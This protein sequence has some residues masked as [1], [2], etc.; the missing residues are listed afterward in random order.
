MDWPTLCKCDCIYAV[1]RGEL[2]RHG[3]R[4]SGASPA[5]R[6]GPHRGPRVECA[7]TWLA[8]GA[9]LCALAS[10]KL[11]RGGQHQ[12]QPPRRGYA[13]RQTTSNRPPL[14]A[15]PVG[16]MSLLLCRVPRMTSRPGSRRWPLVVC[17]S[18]RTPTRPGPGAHGGGV[19]VAPGGH[20][21]G[22]AASVLVRAPIRRR[23]LARGSLSASPE[24]TPGPRH[25][26]LS[27]TPLPGAVCF[28]RRSR[29]PTPARSRG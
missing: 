4:G 12:S 11:R 2:K 15:S 7:V 26:M 20:G 23:P 27:A 21:G 18:R 19:A 25:G 16:C 13:G 22:S 5:G 29:S 14:T 28:G 8:H 9:G 24:I 3:G 17:L 1:P 6:P 10:A